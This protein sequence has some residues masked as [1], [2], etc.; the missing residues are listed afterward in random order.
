MNNIVIHVQTERQRDQISNIRLASVQGSRN[1][2]I[3]RYIMVLSSDI[4]T[5]RRVNSVE[6]GRQYEKTDAQRL[7]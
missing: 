2:D 3:S 7:K 5:I 1:R 4:Q 6:H